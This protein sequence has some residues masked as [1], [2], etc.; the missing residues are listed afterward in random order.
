M[1]AH[2]NY[3]PNLGLDS[4]IRLLKKWFKP[5]SDSQNDRSLWR[6]SINA[7]KALK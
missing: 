3:R 1:Q 4:L 7:S 6:L 2:T 5:M